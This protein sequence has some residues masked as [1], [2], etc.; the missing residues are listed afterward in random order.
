MVDKRQFSKAQNPKSKNG[1]ALG[2]DPFEGIIGPEEAE[3]DIA[4]EESGFPASLPPAKSSEKKDPFNKPPASKEETEAETQTLPAE[5]VAES[6][7]GQK[8]ELFRPTDEGDP[9]I[10]PG[11]KT[12]QVN[13]FLDELVATIDEEIE[14][15]LGSNLMAYFSAETPTS[16]RGEQHVIFTLAGANHAVSTANVSEV[17]ALTTCTP[18]PNVP[19]W[20]VGVTNLRGDILSVVDLGAFLELES[21]EDIE[22]VWAGHKAG[23]E[24]EMMVVHLS[25]NR[26]LLTIGL[27]VDAVQD[28]RYLRLN[29]LN[30]PTIDP[31]DSIK[32]YLHGIYD[33]DGEFLIVLDFDKLLL[34]PQMQQ[35][36]PV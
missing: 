6:E 24:R 16:H 36:E 15:A 1:K 10:E 21:P 32:P 20:L 22:T 8:V 13:A 9:A 14:Q 29:Q 23:K 3:A 11:E 35:F 25:Q 4:T 34:S 33:D 28:I 2:Q 5:T 7:N 12:K 17:G 26:S 30:T 31:M 27:L 19:N 18:V